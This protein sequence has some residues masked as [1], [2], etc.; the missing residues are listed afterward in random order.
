MALVLKKASTT[1]IEIGISLMT[2]AGKV[3]GSF[4]GHARIRTK[5]DNKEMVE[6]VLAQAESGEIDDADSVL[7]REIYERFEGLGNDAG[8]ITGEDAFTEVLEGQ[9]SSALTVSAIRAYYEKIG[10]SA[11]GNSKPSRKR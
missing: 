7:V 3:E 11:R 1:A 10:E 2:D 5:K 4:I 9:Y 6:R 8:A